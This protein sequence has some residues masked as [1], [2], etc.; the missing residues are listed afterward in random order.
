MSTAAAVREGRP[1]TAAD[2]EALRIFLRLIRPRPLD[3]PYPLYAELRHQAP[4][5]PIR[6]P[7]MPAGY[8]VT[9][10]ASCSR[11]LRDPAFGPR[12][13][14]RPPSSTASGFPRRPT[15]G[16]SPRSCRRPE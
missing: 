15:W 2:A 10:F 3:D 1:A 5:L 14:T 16:C 8:L 13:T 11:L 6:F 9:S 12:L 7:G 4:F